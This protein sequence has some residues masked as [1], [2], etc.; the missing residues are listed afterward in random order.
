M[1]LLTTPPSDEIAATESPLLAVLRDLGIAYQI[2]RHAPVFTVEESTDLRGVIPP[3][4]SKNLFV[5]DKKGGRALLVALSEAQVDLKAVA[6][7][8]GLGRLSFVRGEAMQDTLGVVPGSVTP[9]ALLNARVAAAEN[10]PFSVALD[11]RLMA[12][13]VVH[14][15]PLHNAATLG[16]PPEG[17]IRFVEAMGYKPRLLDLG[18]PHS[19]GR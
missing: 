8:L 11:A 9:F 16:V 1:V 4:H 5:K 14:F 6:P 13:P 2:Y 15:H 12:H 10:A 19:E 3:G 18:N 17:L 7:V